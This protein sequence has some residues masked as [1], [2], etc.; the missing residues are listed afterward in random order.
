MLALVVL[1]G[2]QTI[3]S[4][5]PLFGM[6]MPLKTQCSQEP[7]ASYT[8]LHT[9]VRVFFGMNFAVLFLFFCKILRTTSLATCL[10]L[11]GAFGA[12]ST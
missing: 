3:D 5:N 9:H 11:Q 6:H 12:G 2:E 1:L 4:D 7:Q 8:A 10:L